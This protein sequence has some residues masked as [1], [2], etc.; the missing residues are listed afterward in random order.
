MTQL[1]Q[2]L[3]YTAPE[4]LCNLQSHSHI[5][6]QHDIPVRLLSAGS[7]CLRNLLLLAPFEFFMTEMGT[8]ISIILGSL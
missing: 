1:G 7:D 3:Q 8:L 4:W 5:I 6:R 2:A